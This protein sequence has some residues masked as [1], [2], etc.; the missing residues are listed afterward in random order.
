[1][2]FDNDRLIVANDAYFS[3]DPTHFAIFD[4]FAGELGAPIFVPSGTQ[5]GKT[6]YRLKVRPRRVRAGRKVT[7]RATVLADG[8]PLPRARVK[9]RHAVKRAGKHGVARFRVRLP[10]GRHAVRLI[11]G[12]RRTFAKAYIRAR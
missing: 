6:A 11:L 1:V 4:V 10:R 5:P 2:W 9:L 7:V 8:L 12:G 3:G